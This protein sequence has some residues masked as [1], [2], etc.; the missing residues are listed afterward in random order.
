M[1]KQH[2]H[3]GLRLPLTVALIWVAIG[4]LQDPQAFAAPQPR[5]VAPIFAD[6]DSELREATARADGIKHVDSPALIQKLLAG[7]IKTYAYL[8]WHQKTDW[9]DFRLEF[10][11]AAQAARIDVWL[12]LTPPSENSSPSGYVPYG[13]NYVAWATNTAILAQQYPALKAL[14]IDDFNGNEAF[15]T[16]AYVSNMIS[17]AHACCTNLIFLPVNYDLSHNPTAPTRNIST[18]FADAYG[19]YSGGVIFPYL[20]W[21]NK[22]DYSDEALQVAN[23]SDI[24]S[25]KLAQFVVNFPS[26]TPSNAGDYAALTQIIT[27]GAGFPDVPW[28]F[29]FRINDS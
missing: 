3:A 11:P 4:R 13:S 5:L 25:D 19:P 24:L 7:N 21:A 15:F 17:A 14:A 8:V 10:L 9:D 22:N 12:Y 29:P 1:L 23:N 6:Y 18:A 2:H 27:N 16:P 20:N 28:L 26:H